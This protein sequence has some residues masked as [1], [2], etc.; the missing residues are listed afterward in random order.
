MEQRGRNIQTR[1]LELT[2]ARG[3]VAFQNITSVLELVGFE[4]A[5]TIS[6]FGQSSLDVVASI[7]DIA[8]NGLSFVNVGGLVNGVSGL[9]AAFSNTPSADE[10]ILGKLDEVLDNQVKIMK[11]IDEVHQIVYRTEQKVDY[12]NEKMDG[13]IGMLEEV[14]LSLSHFLNAHH[15]FVQA[16]FDQ[17]KEGQ[18]V[19]HAQLRENYREMLNQNSLA[20]LIAQESAL[21]ETFASVAGIHDL[22]ENRIG[23]PIQQQL[24]SCKNKSNFNEC[25]QTAQTT[26]RDIQIL[27]GSIAFHMT[28]T[29]MREEIFFSPMSF[30]DFSQLSE[31][32]ILTSMGE[33]VEKRTGLFRPIGEWLNQHVGEGRVLPS[34][35]T[36]T[37]SSSEREDA[38]GEDASGENTAGPDGTQQAQQ[39]AT[40]TDGT[41]VADG[42][43]AADDDVTA[44]AN[45]N[46]VEVPRRLV[47]VR[48]LDEVGNLEYLPTLFEEYIALAMHLPTHSGDSSTNR[49]ENMD[50]ICTVASRVRTVPSE[51]RKNVR[52][53]FDVYLVYLRQ[54]KAHYDQL[55]AE[56]ETNFKADLNHKIDGRFLFASDLEIEEFTRN[57]S[58][59][60]LESIALHISG[61][62][63]VVHT[64]YTTRKCLRWNYRTR[65]VPEYRCLERREFNCDSLNHCHGRCPLMEKIFLDDNDIQNSSSNLFAH[66]ICDSECVR[67]ERTG[68]YRSVRERTTCAEY[69]KIS[70]GTIYTP[71][72][73]LLTQKIKD[74]RDSSFA[75]LREKFQNQAAYHS[76]LRSGSVPLSDLSRN[77]SLS[78][79]VLD[80][81]LRAGYGSQNLDSERPFQA[82]RQVL[83]SVPYGHGGAGFGATQFL[84]SNRNESEPDGDETNANQYNLHSQYKRVILVESDFNQFS[85]AQGG[86]QKFMDWIDWV[87]AGEEGFGIPTQ[88]PIPSNEVLEEFEQ[89]ERLLGLGNPTQISSLFQFASNYE[90]IRPRSDQ[91]VRTF[92]L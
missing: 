67:A 49:D 64:W 66:D 91:C 63:E 82:I 69:E 92:N 78:K 83:V 74:V 22:F 79:L 65:R 14:Y 45:T 4:E 18:R 12:L 1:E 35:M 47:N 42:T 7:G 62:H 9:L 17:L 75:Y 5:S 3:R 43:D 32:A 15:E 29:L 25:T 44:S 26:M 88:I 34:T 6:A 54:I 51:M 89:T 20:I 61:A 77:L 58:D 55:I 73:S 39:D 68:T 84:Q 30:S 48:A 21:R 59:S 56:A 60:E 38:S 71:K 76:T 10:I 27:L 86:L 31:E 72:R 2:I 81:I 37:V 19:L 53:A 90:D 13:L 50:E 41:A 87:R 46:E 40:E 33:S 85:E 80:T 24:M 52:L 70:T 36:I 57:L 8:I 28:D 16:E 23:S 11:A